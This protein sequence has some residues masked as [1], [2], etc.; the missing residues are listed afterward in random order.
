MARG[1]QKG[2]KKST[3][4]IR[5][6]AF[7][8]YYIVQDERQFTLMIESSTLGQGYYGS[9]PG[10][11]SALIRRRA[12]QEGSDDGMS[13]RGYMNMYKE[14]TDTV[15]KAVSLNLDQEG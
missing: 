8:P 5:D 7:G 15:M 6:E 9:L 11:I 14:L 3:V 4:E 1:K 12:L 2:F 13:L 10:A